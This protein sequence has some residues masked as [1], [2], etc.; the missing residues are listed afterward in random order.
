MKRILLVSLLIFAQVTIAQKLKVDFGSD[1]DGER[2]QIINDGVMGG[3]SKGKTFMFDDCVVFSGTVS[4]R[5]NGGFS[6]YKGPFKKMDLSKYTKIVVK[7]R[8]KG[9][10]MAM[11]M[12]M[13]KRWFLPYYKRDLPNTDWKWVKQEI[14]FSEF[15]KYSVGR[16]KPGAP[17]E[18]ELTN[19]LR[20]GFVTNEKR[21]GDFKMEIDYI[22]FK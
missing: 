5:N 7:Y 2:W 10:A 15:I 18:E 3:L 19:I 12:E 14:L 17:T 22:D 1:L 8:S 11:T 20:L 6:S 16:K 4:L 21:A 9:Y 13:D